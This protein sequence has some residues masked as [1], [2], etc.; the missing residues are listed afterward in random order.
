MHIVHVQCTYLYVEE[1]LGLRGDGHA[2]GQF[3][4]SSSWSKACLWR[5]ISSDFLLCCFWVKLTN[6]LEGKILIMETHCMH[7]CILLTAY[8]CSS[9]YCQALVQVQVPGQVQVRSQVRSRRSRVQGPKTPGLYIKIGL[10]LTTHSPPPNF[11]CARNDSE[12]LLLWLL[13]MFHCVVTVF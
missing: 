10:P 13:T 11:S 9:F 5:I 4:P 3:S 7:N 8:T 6:S 12:P 2:P 1:V